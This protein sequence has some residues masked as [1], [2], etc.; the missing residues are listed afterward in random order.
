MAGTNG[1]F[2]K[3]YAESPFPSKTSL[4]TAR[5]NVELDFNCASARIDYVGKSSESARV[6]SVREKACLTVTPLW[7]VTKGKHSNACCDWTA[8]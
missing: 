3:W 5:G 6:E 1:L 7:R 8:L 4:A 2:F